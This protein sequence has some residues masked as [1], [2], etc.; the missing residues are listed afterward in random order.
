MATAPSAREVLRSRSVKALLALV[1]LSNGGAIVQAVALGKFVF[2]T[3]GRELDLGLVG[4]AEFAPAALLVLVT[5]HVADRFDRRLVVRL[6]LVGEALCAGMLAWYVSTQPTAVGP[7]FALS[8]SYGVFRAFA[9]PASR[10]LY[11]DV[12]DADALPRL[13][14]MTSVSWQSA[15][16][17][18]PV[19][20]G[21]LYVGSPTWPFIAAVVFAIVATFSTLLIKVQYGRIGV[22]DHEEPASLHTA[23][24]GLRL[25]R[26]TPI[27]LGAISLDLFAVLFG[28]AVALLPAIA[29]DQ[30]GVGAVGL[31]WLR[32]AAGIGAAVM[33]TTLAL[34]PL[35]RRV[36][37]TLFVVVG[38]FGAA[39]IVLGVTHSF[40][41]AFLALIVLSAAD[42]VSVFIRS[43]L[44]PLVTPASARG[45]VLAVENV[46]IG[47]SNELGAFES[48]VAGQLLGV[49]PAVVLGGAMTLV[50]AATWSRL[51]PSLR[52]VDRFQDAQE[53]SQRAEPV[54]EEIAPPLAAGG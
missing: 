12:V 50:V 54:R 32:A 25:I 51:F 13:V 33:A 31:G 53:A 35:N 42:A 19:L 48:G 1:A 27:L 36:G 7:I 47:A 6:A 11:A 16:I 46:F 5:G 20:S 26:R 38:I 37:T 18:A 44:T 14:A 15:L 17:V 30:L 41:V 29:E 8:A 4:L 39:T 2:D 43:T 3:T 28:G 9:A 23:L 24:E 40:A 34:H 52:G 22:K 21:F 49:G 10:A 45:R